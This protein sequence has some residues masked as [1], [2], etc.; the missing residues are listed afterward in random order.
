MVH[1]KPVNVRLLILHRCTVRIMTTEKYI[2]YLRVSTA[3]QGA[4]GLGLE[5]QRVNIENYLNGG[6][7]TLLKEFVEVES[8]K[9][10]ERPQLLEALQLCKATGAILLIAKLDRLSRD[11]HFLLGLQKAGVKFVAA[12]M[13]RANDFSVGIMALVAQEERKAISKRTKE[14]LSAAKNR[15]VRL[16]NPGN[17]SLEAAHRGRKSGVAAIKNRADSF[18][19]DC[20]DRIRQLKADGQ[21]LNA[22]A[23]ALNRE[24]IL[25][26]TGKSNAWT[27]RTVKNIIERANTN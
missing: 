3:R 12:D 17:L 20:I 7:W 27:A 23:K 25:T 4:S 13:P 24:G 2:S 26:A 9:N 18:A 10:S 21:S 11:A 8:G 5:A 19:R 22:I 16:G 1:V 15:G 14:A 6:E